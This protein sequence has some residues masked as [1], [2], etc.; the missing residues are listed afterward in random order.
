[1]VTVRLPTALRDLVGGEATI[2]VEGETVREVLATISRDNPGFGR[3]ILDDSGD[4]R[5]FINVF[6]DDE[7]I[8]HHDGVHTPV[9]P[10][11]RVSI[12]PAVAGG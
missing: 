4:M 3:R 8:R 2:D 9:G 10:A 5:R 11:Q 1:M 12:L 7:D 6:V